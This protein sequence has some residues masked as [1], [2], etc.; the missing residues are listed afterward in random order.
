MIRVRSCDL[1]GRCLASCPTIHPCIN[2]FEVRLV[3]PI[4]P[5]QEPEAVQEDRV[6]VV[7]GE[8]TILAARHRHH[9]QRTPRCCWAFLRKR[10]LHRAREGRRDEGPRSSIPKGYREEGLLVLSRQG[11]G[12]GVPV[13]FRC[14][15]R[16]VV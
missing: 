2:G 14:G 7:R 10:S 8:R 9:R 15:G 11:K 1:R 4:G 3:R 6:S 12:W 16:F 13:G 5:C